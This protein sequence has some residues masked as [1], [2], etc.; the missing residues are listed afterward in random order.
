MGMVVATPIGHDDAAVTSRNDMITDL[1]TEVSV[2]GVPVRFETNSPSVLFAIDAAYLRP[3]A[4][5][6]ETAGKL[7]V[8]VIVDP[9]L[10]GLPRLAEVDRA[11]R[12]HLA[13]RLGDGYATA[14][15]TRGEAVA[16]V[17]AATVAHPG[18]REIVLD[19]LTLFLVTRAD[20]CPFHAAAVVIDGSAVLVTGASGLGKSSFTYAALRDGLAILAD[21]AVYVERHERLR[22]WSFARR[23]HVPVEATRF[24]PELTGQPGTI[25]PDGRTKI[26]VEVP[27]AARATSPWSGGVS[28]CLLARGSEDRLPERLGPEEATDE[29]R[30]TLQGGFLRFAAEVETLVPLL[31]GGGCWRLPVTAE[32]A[33]LV[34]RMR[35][36]LRDRSAHT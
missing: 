22:L 20:R 10:T 5:V 24:F 36:L 2:C 18:F 8:R 27:P 26:G 28:L 30:A 3:M 14:D 35:R 32:P 7:L 19:H 34:R 9:G 12:D 29:V 1:R 16:R 6:D 23:I 25:R 17:S 11:D 15:C 33:E 13:L 21:D 31:T 4:E